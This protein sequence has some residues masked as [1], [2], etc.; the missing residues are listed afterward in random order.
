MAHPPERP[1]RVP[2][3]FA[4]ALAT[5]EPLLLVGGQAVNLW[6]LYYEDRTKELSPFVSRDVD[7]LGD[8]QT[9][10]DLAAALGVKP[11]FF[12]LKP[13]SNEV[14]IIIAKDHAGHAL[15]IE[16]LRNV[17]GVSNEELHDSAFEMAISPKS[18]RVR[19][20]GPVAL[21]KAKI[22]NAADLAQAGRQD[23]RHVRILAKLIPAFLGDLVSS[24]RAGQLEERALINQL[25]KLL[26]VITSSKA[27]V[28]FAALKLEP[29]QLFDGLNETDSKKLK[30]FL[31][32]RLPRV[33]N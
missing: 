17:H 19:V 5:P 13:P 20:P 18:V 21:L 14:G 1:A 22:A 29:I 9:L 33:F 10:T 32:K 24:V 16:V 26:T 11:Q 12:P 30:A 8:R 7:V 23:L 3:D 28:V 15:L 27:R 6:A 25:E 31:T 2:S 4:E